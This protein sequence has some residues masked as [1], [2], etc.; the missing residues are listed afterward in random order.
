[1][2][3]VGK[4]SVGLY[5]AR[6]HLDHFPGGQL[7][8]NLNG[9]GLGRPVS[10][11]DA[12][13]R[14]LFDLRVPAD[15]I[16]ANVEQRAGRLSQLLAGRQAL[17]FLDNVRDSAHVRPLLEAISDCF[18][19]VTSRARLSGLVIRDGVDSLTVRPLST[20]ES[21]AL[22]R[23]EVGD[24]RVHEERIALRDLARLTGGLPLALRIVGH[25]VASRP[26]TRLADVVRE[27][28]GHSAIVTSLTDIDDET[29]TVPGAFS[30]S[31]NAL[32]SET[33]RLFRLLGLH[34]S[35]ILSAPAASALLGRDAAAKPHLKLLTGL[36][37]LEREGLHLYRLHDLLHA[38]AADRAA[39]E[40][41]TDDR[42]AARTR[43]VD[44]YFR[45]AINAK[46]VL[47]PH[48]QPVPLLAAVT[49]VIPLVFDNEHDAISWCDQ[50][51]SNLIVMIQSAAEHGLH[52]YTWRM[53]GSLWDAFER[54]G[55]QGDFLSVLPLALESARTLGNR[56]A[57]TA[58]LNTLGRLHF[59]RRDYQPALAYFEEGLAVA[60]RIGDLIF[61]GASKHNIA[62]VWLELGQFAA[63]LEIYEQTLQ[64]QRDAGVR[65]G[66]A[67]TLHRLGDVHRHR[68]ALEPA[69]RYYR[70]ALRIRRAIGHVR[71]QG[72]TLTELGKMHHEKAEYDE[73]LGYCFRAL[74]LHER[75]HDKVRATETLTTLAAIYCDTGEFAESSRYA[76]QAVTFAHSIQ[77]SIARA[78]A[79]ECLGRAQLGAGNEVAAKNAWLE[80]LAVFEV[81]SD[82]AA[83]TIRRQLEAL[84]PSATTRSESGAVDPAKKPREIV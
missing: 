1:M 68:G 2:P 5:W 53:A 71:G 37:L 46:Y 52:E 81:T 21:I 43:M 42:H 24:E 48:S 39:A 56:Q 80:A 3:G 75:T 34:P 7:F 82:P 6:Q 65:D 62:C 19:L 49:D 72:D 84:E 15:L 13:S 60:K 67:Y 30:L 31:Y 47:A 64:L 78:T 83:R 58:M 32:P 45:T 50:E 63:A 27:L 76:H 9:Y 8:V 20:D 66:E 70:D 54:S 55:F 23:V 12:M 36:H 73:A 74:S 11:G 38:Y 61:E 10:A 18:V 59:G 25:N 41:T 28:D 40:E 14:L 16:P 69:L 79:L 26:Q 29:A 4:T 22:L 57:E 17:V 35:P 33:A 51:R 44:W 77:D